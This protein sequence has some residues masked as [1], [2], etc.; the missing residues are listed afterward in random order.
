LAKVMIDYEEKLYLA[1]A[2]LRGAGFAPIRLVL[3]RATRLGPTSVDW[4]RGEPTRALDLDIAFEAGGKPHILAVKDEKT[5][6]A[7]IGLPKLARW[8]ASDAGQREPLAMIP[9]YEVARLRVVR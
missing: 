1:L 5:F 7:P 2:A 6:R 9:T 3:D 4:S 8:L